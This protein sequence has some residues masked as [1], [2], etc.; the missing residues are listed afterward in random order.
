M[1]IGLKAHVPW[2]KDPAQQFLVGDV[3]FLHPHLDAGAPPADR[4][5][6]RRTIRP[7][8]HATFEGQLRL[9]TTNN[10][11]FACELWP[12]MRFCQLVVE[13]LGSP[14]VAATAPVVAAA[15]RRRRFG[16]QGHR[17]RCAT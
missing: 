13:R 3:P 15:K 12:G 9:E 10:G 5:L 2:A 4:D 7:T 14:A 8:V 11:P 16:S 1:V 6:P 17:S